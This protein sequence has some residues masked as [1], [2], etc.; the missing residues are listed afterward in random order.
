MTTRI[1][2]VFAACLAGHGWPG[3]AA[4]A[5]R[6]PRDGRPTGIARTIC[7]RRAGSR[8]GSSQDGHAGSRGAWT[9]RPAAPCARLPGRGRFLVCESPDPRPGERPLASSRRPPCRRGRRRNGSA[10][11]SAA[12]GRT[13]C[14]LRSRPHHPRATRVASRPLRGKPGG[15]SGPLSKEDPTTSRRYAP[16]PRSSSGAETSLQP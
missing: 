8:G 7:A 2:V 14:R 3:G 16:W 6:P 9:A 11:T 1:L 10:R 15:T 4:R 5:S 13:R 12:S